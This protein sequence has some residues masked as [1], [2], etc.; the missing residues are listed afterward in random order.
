MES[1]IAKCLLTHELNSDKNHKTL[2]EGLEKIIGTTPLISLQILKSP[3]TQIVLHKEYDLM[4][5]G[6]RCGY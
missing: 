4:P 6:R 5:L 1:F 2:T 3:V